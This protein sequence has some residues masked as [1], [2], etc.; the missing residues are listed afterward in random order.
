VLAH[1]EPADPVQEI[2]ASGCEI[3]ID[4]THKIVALDDRNWGYQIKKGATWTNAAYFCNCRTMLQSI[5]RRMIDEHLKAMEGFG[6]NQLENKLD[7]VES[8]ITK[9]LQKAIDESIAR[10][11]EEAIANQE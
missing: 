4:S 11:R 6:F 3:S 10:K 5:S 8:N 7:A 2:G 1:T 9:L